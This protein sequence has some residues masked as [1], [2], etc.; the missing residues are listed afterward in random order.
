[1]VD[2]KSAC[3]CGGMQC[4]W[5]KHMLTSSSQGTLWM[6]LFLEVPEQ[7]ESRVLQVWGPLYEHK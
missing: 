5:V 4:L 2:D 7:V 1:M 6:L 3:I